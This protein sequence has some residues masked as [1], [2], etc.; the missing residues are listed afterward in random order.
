[1]ENWLSWLHL[2]IFFRIAWNAVEGI[3]LLYWT[4]SS[5]EESRNIKITFWFCP[6][7]LLCQDTRPKLSNTR[8]SQFESTDGMKIPFCWKNASHPVVR[9]QKG[10]HTPG[11]SDK[12]IYLSWLLFTSG[13]ENL[14][15]CGRKEFISTET[16]ATLIKQHVTDWVLKTTHGPRVHGIRK[17]TVCGNR[18]SS[19]ILILRRQTVE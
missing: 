9:K 19:R 18:A 11:D 16:A 12:T 15:S 4:C 3:I 7:L 13:T 14:P 5:G 8:P 2:T 1:M 10:F 17:Q 6:S